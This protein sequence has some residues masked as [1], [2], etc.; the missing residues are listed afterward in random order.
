MCYTCRQTSRRGPRRGQRPLRDVGRCAFPTTVQATPTALVRAE[1]SAAAS[2]PRQPASGGAWLMAHGSWGSRCSYRDRCSYSGRCRLAAA[3]DCADSA[4]GGTYPCASSSSRLS[5]LRSRKY[6]SRCSSRMLSRSTPCSSASRAPSAFC[7]SVSSRHLS[8]K[9]YSS[10]P[11]C[12]KCGGGCSASEGSTG[13]PS[14]PPSSRANSTCTGR[15]EL[16]S[17]KRLS[18]SSCCTLAATPRLS[19]STKP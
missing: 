9:S 18:V 8:A 1:T 15:G 7:E 16:P 10:V 2:R 13:A 3:E 12:A 5:L 14:A 11:G 6:S 17:R 19:Y 4:E